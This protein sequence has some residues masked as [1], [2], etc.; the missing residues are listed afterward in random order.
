MKPE[1]L[2]AALNDPWHI[3]DRMTPDEAKRL[4]DAFGRLRPLVARMNV[5]I[6]IAKRGNR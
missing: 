5:A 4:I 3:R 2:A 1:R 6:E